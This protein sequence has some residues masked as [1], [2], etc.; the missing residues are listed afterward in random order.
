MDLGGGQLDQRGAVPHIGPQRHDGGRGAETAAQESVD[1]EIPEPLAVG[2][3]TLA[4]R[5]VADVAGIHQQHLEAV[6]LQNVKDRDPIHAGGFHGHV[7]DATR[8]EPG[9]QAMRDRR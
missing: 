2:D 7:R 8:G 5:H 3:V 4:P 6:R 9:G 1:V